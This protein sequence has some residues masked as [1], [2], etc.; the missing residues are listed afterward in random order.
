MTE[1][2]KKNP[3]KPR[4]GE[5]GEP[6]ALAIHVALLGNDPRRPIVS[7][8]RTISLDAVRAAG[9]RLKRLGAAREVRI[10]AVAI[11]EGDDTYVGYEVFRIGQDGT[12]ESMLANLDPSADEENQHKVRGLLALT[13]E[14]EAAFEQSI[15]KALEGARAPG[16]G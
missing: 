5:A 16:S 11:P 15:A 6:G 3:A 2:T 7:M 14:Q 4:P 13:P 10:A 1:T 12:P 8:S 9:V